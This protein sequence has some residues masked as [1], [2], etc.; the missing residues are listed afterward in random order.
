MFGCLS[1]ESP[2][3]KDVSFAVAAVSAVRLQEAEAPPELL[4]VR[5]LAGYQRLFFR[6]LEMDQHG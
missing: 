3:S 5:C 1:K 2:V 4:G 6:K